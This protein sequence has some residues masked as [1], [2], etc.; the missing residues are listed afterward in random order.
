MVGAIR[1]SRVL[2]VE[3]SP[4]D[5]LFQQML[6]EQDG[7]LIACFRDAKQALGELASQPD[8]YDAVVADLELEGSPGLRFADEIQRIR[9]GIPLIL[10]TARA[11]ELRPAVEAT[12]YA[13]VKAAVLAKPLA[14]EEFRTAV[15][16]ALARGA[17]SD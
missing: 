16:S 14:A 6:L 12:E 13:G 1:N 3:S 11:A 7:Y 9:P 10:T 4:E 15:R 2:V 17:V 5:T 8:L